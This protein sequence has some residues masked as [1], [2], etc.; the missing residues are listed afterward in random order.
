PLEALAEEFLDRMRRGERPS[1]K[2]FL[3][4]VPERI[5]EFEE[6]LSALLLVEDVKL[7]DDATSAFAQAGWPGDRPV[8][9]RF[10]DFRILRELGHGGMG[11]VYEAEQESLNRHVAI[12]VL[13]PGTARSPQ[14]L[15]RFLREA[16]AAA[17]LHHTNIVPVFSV[18]ERE[19]LHYYAMQ[20]IRGLS[21]DKVLREVR[22][23]NGQAAVDL[24]EATPTHPGTSDTSVAR[25]LFA[26]HFARPPAPAQVES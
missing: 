19:G 7:H 2:E 6:L 9:E 13:A 25:S 8:L 21:L 3:A 26:G 12:K 10:G 24:G 1:A 16:R 14:I 22:R 15:E 17:Q 11:I 20:F 5:G 4:R 18:G 23:L